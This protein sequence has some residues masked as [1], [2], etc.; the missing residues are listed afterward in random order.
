MNYWKLNLAMLWLSQLLIM[1]GFDA[2]IPFIPLFIKDGLGVS[3]PAA[4]MM[5]VSMFNFWGSMGYAI[6]N[7]IWGFLADKFGVKPMLLRGT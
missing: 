7:P 4:L 5:Y 6:F 3:D 2:M 1:A